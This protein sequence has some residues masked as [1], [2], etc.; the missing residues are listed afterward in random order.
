[1][2]TPRKRSVNLSNANWQFCE[3]FGHFDSVEDAVNYLLNSIALNTA[4]NLPQNALSH[5]ELTPKVQEV[6]PTEETGGG[7][8]TWDMDI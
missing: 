3:R 1:M 4:P 6:S 2:A 8:E 7:I 5:P